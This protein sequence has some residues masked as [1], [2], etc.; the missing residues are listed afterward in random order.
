MLLFFRVDGYTSLFINVMSDS[1]LR[2]RF[3]SPPFE[4]FQLEMAMRWAWFDY[5]REVIGLFELGD[6]VL[7]LG[8]LLDGPPFLKIY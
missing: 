8:K 1:K 3:D 7:F 4:W 6:V 5:F 2:N